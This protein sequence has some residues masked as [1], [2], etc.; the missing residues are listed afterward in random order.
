MSAAEANDLEN[1]GSIGGSDDQS[2]EHTMHISPRELVHDPKPED[3]I[4]GRGSKGSHPGN[5]RFRQIVMEQRD[6]YQKATKREE[7][8][9]ITLDIVQRL[10]SCKKPARFLLRD[11]KSNCWYD[12][13]FEYAKEKVSHALRSRPTEDKRKR[14]KPK[15]KAKRKPSFSPELE[16]LVKGMIT[17]QQSLLQ[18][19][20]DKEISAPPKPKKPSS[21]TMCEMERRQLS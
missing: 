19:M 3:I 5:K 9:K 7:K 20:I 15:K 18:S 21:W 17:D 8:T 1:D 11:T 12:V 16:G 13:G 4:C 2:G 6:L 14:S 10:M